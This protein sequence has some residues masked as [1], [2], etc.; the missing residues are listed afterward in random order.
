MLA[1]AARSI[2]LLLGLMALGLSAAC[3]VQQTATTTTTAAPT[4]PPNLRQ[5]LYPKWI[6][7]QAQIKWP[8][9]NG[10]A[11]A[12]V[13]ETLAVGTLIDRFGSEGGTFF[14]PKGES[15][16]ARAV[17]YV[18]SK[19]VYT[20]YRVDKPLHVMDCKAAAWFDEPGGATQFQTDDPAFKL[21]ESSAIEAVPG[22]SAG[23]ANAAPLCKGP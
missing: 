19:M 12:P 21:R 18:C 11:A 2:L 3:Q 5:S 14:S 6:D 13:S 16:D 17:P 23:N 1:R 15:F 8:P 20:V 9:N 7:A 10:C 4:L 22:D